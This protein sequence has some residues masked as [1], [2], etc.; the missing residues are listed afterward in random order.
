MAAKTHL[1]ESVIVGWV[2][3]ASAISSLTSG[4]ARKKIT[5]QMTQHAPEEAKILEDFANKFLSGRTVGEAEQELEFLTAQL[6]SEG[7]WQKTPAQRAALEKVDGKTASRVAATA[8][9]I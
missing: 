2:K 6:E 7:Y 5:P 9:W 8:Y 3:T 1:S 4:N